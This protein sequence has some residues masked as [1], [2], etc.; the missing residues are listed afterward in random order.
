MKKVEVQ[1]RR[2]L[3][4]GFFQVDELTLSHELL[5]GRMSR[6]LRRL[7]LER[8]DAV[9][10]LLFRPADQQVVLV[11][12]FRA[13]ASQRGE[14]WLLEV[15]A[16]IPDPGEE[17]AAAARR[18]VLEETGYQVE[19]L[20]HISTFYTTPG[21]SSE[22]IALYYSQVDETQRVAP[23]GGCVEEDEDIEVVALGLAEL[24]G[25][26][27]GGQ[28]ADAKTLIALMWLR[29]RLVDSRA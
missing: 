4:D 11:R 9:A 12:Q 21:G 22:R 27:E 14:G 8:G 29:R 10:V 6:P 2:R 1:G 17:L 7:I 13:P 24:W 15:V 20:E 3:L 16:G 26:L 5:D 23:G 19:E 18:E 25:L 28:I